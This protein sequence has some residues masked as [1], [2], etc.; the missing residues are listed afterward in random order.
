MAG[1]ADHRLIYGDHPDQFVEIWEPAEDVLG[2]I[3]L[4]H[5]GYW[6]QLYDLD[7]TRRIAAHTSDKGWRVYNIEYR[8]VADHFGVWP[9][10]AADIVHAASLADQHPQVII[11]HSAGG[12]LALWL[13]A[14]R[15]GAD[16]VIALA[17]LADLVAASSLHLSSDATTE[18]F[19]GPYS[20]LADVYESASPH[21]LV[22]LGIP[23]VVVHGDAD[24]SVPQ[25]LAISYVQA[26]TAAGDAVEF[27]DP[28]GV[29]HMDVIEPEHAVWRELDRTLD[30]WAT[31]L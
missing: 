27:L 3:V 5:G 4:I 1:S 22:P 18:L 9:D 13:A 17:P 19:G 26:A 8:R 7:S 24:T 14:Q 21:V 6:R 20:E 2:S 10:M 31:S 12:H 15:Q 11:G 30:G 29:D 28:S 25:Q 16:A 23:T